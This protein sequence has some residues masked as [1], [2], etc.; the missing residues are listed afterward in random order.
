MLLYRHRGD[1]VSNGHIRAKLSEGS[2]QPSTHLIREHI[3]QLRKVLAGSRYQIANYRSL[4]YEL[5]V[6]DDAASVRPPEV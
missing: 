1:V 4:G 5:I 2:D 3:R 6:A